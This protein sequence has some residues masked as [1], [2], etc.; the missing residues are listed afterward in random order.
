MTFKFLIHDWFFVYGWQEMRKII[1]ITKFITQIHSRCLNWNQPLSSLSFFEGWL[2]YMFFVKCLTCLQYKLLQFITKLVLI[3]LATVA[4]VDI[5][6]S[7]KVAFSLVCSLIFS[8]YVETANYLTSKSLPRKLQSVKDFAWYKSPKGLVIT[9]MSNIEFAR[10]QSAISHTIKV[11]WYSTIFL[12]LGTIL[13]VADPVTD[14]LT[15]REFYLND[16]KT[17]FGVGLVFVILPSLVIS[18]LYYRTHVST[19][20]CICICLGCDKLAIKVCSIPDL[21][22]F[23]GGIHWPFL[24]ADYKHLFCAPGTLKSYGMKS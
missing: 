6:R 9:V 16:H 21:I 7:H 22:Y 10:P 8:G 5:I 1:E 12:L 18:C 4:M 11:K 15:L 20:L 19:L 17:W 23:L 14:I 3:T 13:A 24:I 2:H